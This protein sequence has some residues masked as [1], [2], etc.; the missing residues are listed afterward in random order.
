MDG[1]SDSKRILE[2]IRNSNSLRRSKHMVVEAIIKEL[3]EGKNEP[4]AITD[5]PKFG[6]NVLTTQIDS[7]K[8]S[9]Y[10]GAKFSK[11]NEGDPESNPLVYYPNTGNLVFSGTIPALSDMKFQFSLNDITNAPFIF[12]NGLSLTKN[13]ISTLNKMNGFYE[14]WKEEWQMAGDMLE[15]LKKN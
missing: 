14:N 13:V 5:D 3:K 8:T 7:F 15:S 9:V 4:I 2:V 12:V 1:Y 11:A 10:S 6:T